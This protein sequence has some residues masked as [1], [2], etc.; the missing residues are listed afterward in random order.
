MELLFKS[1]AEIVELA[2]EL[3]SVLCIVAGILASIVKTAKWMG[4][5]FRSLEAKKDS[6]VSF[7]IW[8][9]LA[10]EFALAAD[11][12]GTA[13][14]PTWDQIGQLAAI[15]VIRTVLNFFL[16]KDLESF[17]RPEDKKAAEA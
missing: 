13:I 6:W 15:A 7:A 11:I 9:M 1:F 10:L 5:G 8:I 2:C 3:G 4:R 14:A 16:A 17:A 12:V